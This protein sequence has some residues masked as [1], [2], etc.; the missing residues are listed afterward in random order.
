MAKIRH[1]WS[2]I[3]FLYWNEFKT[4][5]SCEC[6]MWRHR[7]SLIFV[8]VFLEIH[9]Y[10]MQYQTA[11]MGNTLEA[12]DPEISKIDDSQMK[13]DSL[14]S[15]LLVFVLPPTPCDAK[16]IQ[17]WLRFFY[18]CHQW[19]KASVTKKSQKLIPFGPKLLKYWPY[20]LYQPIGNW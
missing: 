12:S 3:M 8:W 15:L 11:V 7:N 19:I 20:Q 13:L 2:Y 14:P 1:L 9:F 10:N 17:G 4:V 5:R 18:Y 16:L 6:F